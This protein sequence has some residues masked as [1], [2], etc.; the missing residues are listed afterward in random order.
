MRDELLFHNGPIVEDKSLFALSPDLRS[1]ADVTD[2]KL[3]ADRRDKR[4][5]ILKEILRMRIV[6]KIYFELEALHASSK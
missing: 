1:L 5:E 3:F 2:D 4:I 6:H